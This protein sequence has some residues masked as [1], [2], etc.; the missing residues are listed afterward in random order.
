MLIQQDLVFLWAPAPLHC[1]YKAQ[2]QKTVS[3]D[4][5]EVSRLGLQR[6]QQQIKSSLN[7]MQGRYGFIMI[8]IKAS[9]CLSIVV[10]GW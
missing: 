1:I 7:E 2:S 10:E 3:K 6:V 9:I 8:S 4:R 5:R